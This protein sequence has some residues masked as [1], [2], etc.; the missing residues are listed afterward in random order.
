MTKATESRVIH[1]V[2]TGF[3]VPLSSDANRVALRGETF[4]LTPEQIESTRGRDG[5]SVFDL[6]TD[7][8]LA[9]WGEVRFQDGP[10]PEGMW[11]DDDV[12][13]RAAA[14]ERALED[15]NKLPT[16]AEQI[17]AR[18]E[19]ENTL[20]RVMTSQSLGIQPATRYY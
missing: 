15:A 8:Q 11:A 13:V 10:A 19:V 16:R 18:I 5:Q 6:D 12:S 2:K 20:G 14:R 1:V 4:E 17:A 9:R 7:A 3:T